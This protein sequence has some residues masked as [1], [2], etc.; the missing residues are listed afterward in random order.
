MCAHQGPELHPAGSRIE[1]MLTWLGGGN[2]RELAGP[3]ERSTHAI[4]GVVIL[5]DAVLAW[6]VATLA[7]AGSTHWPVPA[8]LPWTLLLGVLVGAVT[9]AIASG[10]TR[11]WPGVLGRGAVAVAVGVV[12]GELAALVLFSGT[13]D[14]RLDEQAAR[15]ADAT[16]AVVQASA[17][18]GQARTARTA[19]DDA[20]EQAR[21]HRDEVLV[22]ARCE[23]NPTPACPETR[24]TGVPGPGPETQTANELLADAQGELDNALA[25]RESRAPQL[26]A[27]ISDAG[28][29]I[30]QA[31]EAAIAHADRGLGARWV[32][33]NDYTFGSVGALALRLLT[34]AFF[35]LLTLLPLIIKLWRGETTHDRGAVARA[36]RDRAELD[37]DTAIAVKRAEVRAAAEILWAEQQL[38][39]ARLAVEAQIE[40]DRAQHRRRVSEALHVPVHAVSHRIE[41]EPKPVM[42]DV[43]LPIAAEAEAA[44]FAADQ[45]PA[46]GH[47]APVKTAE[48]LP[49]RVESAGA[50]EPRD[51]G[52]TSLIPSIPGVTRAAVRWVRPLVPPFVVRAIDTTTQP[53]RAARQVFEEVEE[54]TFLLKRTHKV[55]VSSEEGPEAEQ[56]G[57]AATDTMADDTTADP[58][59]VE[60]SIL[61]SDHRYRDG[62]D[63]EPGHPPLGAA[64]GDMSVAPTGREAQAEL[65]GQDGP[66]QL[67]GPDGP[68]QLPPAE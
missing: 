40:I 12:I 48:D 27:E 31:R 1:A 18:L 35:A 26:D 58:R 57:S 25:A 53:L 34:I 5:L 41:E 51:E 50:V 6:L 17:D 19:L 49:A 37:A 56:R 38:A 67:R 30:A 32:A 46:D 33:M 8:I 7:V 52:G 15:T 47:H 13:I 21:A 14:R 55:T 23:Y 16:P 45:S 2:L 24:I 20:V 28:R 54:I 65:T 10:P 4:T 36:E 44:S 66:R 11:S 42:E 3:H 29:A 60:S 43:Y 9:R 62:L 64:P 68:P 61:R 22:V 59:R 39:S 63:A